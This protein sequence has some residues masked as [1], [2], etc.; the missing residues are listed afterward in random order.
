MPLLKHQP[1]HRQVVTLSC[2]LL[3]PLIVVIALAANRTR[4]ERMGEVR[5]E[6]VTV[7]VTAAAYLDEYL[8][9]LDT[10]ASALIQHPAV[11]SFDRIGRGSSCLLDVGVRR[12]PS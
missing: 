10:L 2:L 12:T 3:L 5:Q 8:K 6:A 7:A 1:L 9:G 11:A 4:L